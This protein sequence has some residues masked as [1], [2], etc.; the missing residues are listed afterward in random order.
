MRRIFITEEIQSFAEEYRGNLFSG[1]K[2]ADFIKPEDGLRQL[3]D[4]ITEKG[5]TWSVD[6]NLYVD[7]LNAI[8]DNYSE[9]ITLH[10]SEFRPYKAQKFSMLNDG[11]L[12]SKEWGG[13]KNTV[14]FSDMILKVMHYSDARKELMPYFE[15]MGI[16]TCVYCN[17]QYANTVYDEDGCPVGGFE[18]DH[19]YPKDA[20]P[21]LCISFFNLQPSCG[22]CNKWKGDKSCKF[23]LYTDDPTEINPFEFRLEKQSIIKYMLIQSPETL[24]IL[25]NSLDPVLLQNYEELFHTSLLYKNFGIE[26]EQ[27]VWRRKI[28][29]SFFNDQLVKQFQKLFP[30]K[31]AEINRFLYGFYTDER[32]IHKQ[33]LTKLKQ[34]VARQ[35]KLIK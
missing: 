16:R 19:F 33:P 11:Q 31:S 12:K 9:I 5:N 35:L 27:I 2:R 13:A 3:I 24:K 22:V 6:W 25:F 18:L 34:D 14:S 15:K 23:N 30:G 4:E 1:H 28:N 32:D 26:A 29:N 17:A 10:P 20:Y 21:F 7:Y 8:I